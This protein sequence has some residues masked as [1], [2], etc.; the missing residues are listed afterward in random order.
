MT[1]HQLHVASSVAAE[2]GG[3]LEL[4]GET[5]ERVTL[6]GKIRSINNAPS[7]VEV[8][9]DDG[10]GIATIKQYIDGDDDASLQGLTAGHIHI[11]V[12]QGLTHGLAN[13]LEAGEMDDCV[14]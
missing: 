14:D 9:L 7:Y 10:S 6:V 5:V 11:P 1:V 12:A 8:R 3:D 13:G 2:T 4:D